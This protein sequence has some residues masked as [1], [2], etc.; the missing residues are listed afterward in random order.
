M[1]IDITRLKILILIRL[2]SAQ[3][4]HKSQKCQKHTYSYETLSLSLIKIIFK[5]TN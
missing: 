4:L 2:V 5:K 3:H 1:M